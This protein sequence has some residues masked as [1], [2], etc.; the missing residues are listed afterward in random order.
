MSITLYDHVITID[1]E[2]ELIWR[3]PWSVSTILYLIVRYCGDTTF[4]VG[5]AVFLSNGLPA[6]VCYRYFL[7]QSWVSTPV[8]WTMQLVMQMRVFALYGRSKKIAALTGLLFAGEMVVN[9]WMLARI[10]SKQHG[11][12]AI[13]LPY[14]SVAICSMINI[15]SF[16]GFWY[17]P[18]ICFETVLFALALWVGIRH[19]QDMRKWT[20]SGI[21]RVIL[22][23][24]LFYF[25]AVLTAYTVS[26]ALW[27]TMG[28]I[29]IQITEG[30]AMSAS[31]IMGSRLV[32]NM[33]GAFWTP[34]RGVSALTDVSELNAVV[35]Y[36]S[37][38]DTTSKYTPTS[39][40][41]P[42]IS[43]TDS[44]MELGVVRG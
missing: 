13:T 42:R 12:T 33:R 2:V 35:P 25:A 23:D 26:M 5:S 3:K 24:S 40:R 10:Y 30:F 20:F 37:E 1:E 17:L 43:S 11:V 34:P 39:P 21:L 32:L 16:F 41:H 18:M 6:S 31:V 27:L 8:V 22:R 44:D 19:V 7:F 15:P 14:P 28:A 29:F 4:I 38:S 36:P 9:V